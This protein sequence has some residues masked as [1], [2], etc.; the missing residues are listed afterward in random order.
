MVMLAYEAIGDFARR[1]ASLDEGSDEWQK[2][3][4]EFMAYAGPLLEKLSYH[5]RDFAPR[6]DGRIDCTIEDYI[7]PRRHVRCILDPLSG[8]IRPGEGG[9]RWQLIYEQ[10]N[11]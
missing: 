5:Y 1:L 9:G 10:T 7:N 8:F 4:R 2:V 11:K 3:R 6:E